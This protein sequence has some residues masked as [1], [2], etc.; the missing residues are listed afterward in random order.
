MKNNY[1]CINYVVESEERMDNTMKIVVCSKNKAKNAAVE[2]VIKEFIESYDI[3]SIDTSSGVSE[4]PIGDEEGITGCI[5]R[6][7][8]A[9]TKVSDAN[10]YIAMEG[11]LTKT[12]D[13]TFLCGW[14]VIYDNDTDEYLYGCSA[15]INVPKEIIKNLSKDDRLSDIVANY[16]GSTEEEVRNYGTNG[17]LTHGAYTRTDEFTDSVL[18][19]ISSKFSKL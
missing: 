13:E 18:C 1:F 12:F 9:K 17:M 7:K 4:T 19:A 16:I 8:D 14:T 6:I 10:L 3:Y 15:K 5:N 11:I 2:N